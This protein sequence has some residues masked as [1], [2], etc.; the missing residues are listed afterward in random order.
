MAEGLRRSLKP[1]IEEITK[2]AGTRAEREVATVLR[3]MERGAR[4]EGNLIPAGDTSYLDLVARVFR[5][6]SPQRGIGETG[7][8]P[9]KPRIILP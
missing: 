4:H 2:G 1:V 7:S 3:G 5:P 8:D 9:S 6:P